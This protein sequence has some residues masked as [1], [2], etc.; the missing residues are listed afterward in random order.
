M[1]ICDRCGAPVA[2]AGDA[3]TSKHPHPRLA[4]RV[5]IWV[6]GDKAGSQDSPALESSVFA[7]EPCEHLLISAVGA[8]V[9]QWAAVR[10]RRKDE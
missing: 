2:K 5:Q 7:C 6:D 8:A 1:I 9:E 4:G 10:Q 3:M